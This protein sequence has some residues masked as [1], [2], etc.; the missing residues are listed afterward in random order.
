[1]QRCTA[2][3]LSGLRRVSAV[4]IWRWPD[5]ISSPT[6]CDTMFSSIEEIKTTTGGS[7]RVQT[8]HTCTRIAAERNRRDTHIARL[9]INSG[10]K[11]NKLKNCA[12]ENEESSAKSKKVIFLSQRVVRERHRLH[13]NNYRT[14][15]LL[16]LKWRWNFCKI[17][18][19]NVEECESQILRLKFGAKPRND[20]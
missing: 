15:E 19:P 3:C 9:Q 12:A 17:F 8:I 2:S 7:F 18:Y 5:P 4:C 16:I 14:I 20:V 11:R 10:W 6:P 13:K 1:M